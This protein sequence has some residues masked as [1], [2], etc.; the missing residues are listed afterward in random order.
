MEWARR[1]IRH[2]SKQ[3]MRATISIDMGGTNLRAGLIEDGKIVRLCKEP[4]KA[5]G[6][7]E[8]ILEQIYQMVEHL[9]FPEVERIG[10]AVPSVVDFEKGIVYDVQNVPSW[11]EVHLKELLEK[12]FGIP[13]TV[14][15]DVNCFVNAEL[16]YGAAQGF[17]N[18]VGITLGT[19]VGAGIVANGNIFR[20]ANTGAGEIG[21]M[22]YL[23]SIYED[24]TS[25]Q[26]FK[27]HKT[28]GEIEAKKAHIGDVKAIEL[29]RQFGF[30]LGK[31][32]QVILFAYDPEC[33]VIGGGIAQ[34]SLWFEESMRKS[35]TEGF[36]Y[37][38]EIERVKIVF[39]TL[40]DCN[41]LGA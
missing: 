25:S 6:S 16:R 19:G 23:D 29:W 8:E 39:S 4:C 30:H 7:E 15:N 33:I 27:K 2:Q 17:S 3:E 9:K 1:N 22:A 34:S 35:L 10:V 36:P 20:G 26:F 11:K 24:Y 41:L 37:Q 5:N 31:L 40:K 18:V 21:C 28:T 14:D 13:T 12:R 32:L 38:Y